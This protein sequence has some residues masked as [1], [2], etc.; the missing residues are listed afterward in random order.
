MIKLGIIA[1]SGLLPITVAKS[2]RKAGGDVVIAGLENY[3]T[4]EDFV[5]YECQIFNL[6][7]VGAILKFFKSHDISNLVIVGHIKRPDF[8]ALSLDLK[9]TLLLAKIMAA[10][11][12]GDDALLKL[13]ANFIES[14][15]F[16]INSPMKYMNSPSIETKI[17]PRKIDIENIEYAKKIA[18]ELGKFDIGQSVIVENGYILGVEAAEGTDALIERCG[19]I[20]KSNKSSILVKISK[21]RQ[22]ERLDIPTIGVE[23]I[24]NASK[25]NMAGMAIEKGRV[26]V[27]EPDKVKETAD[28]LGLFVSLI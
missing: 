10:K 15:G 22:D 6:G 11:L 27:L 9:G 26:I 20:R 18:L 25:A 5:S 12:L 1:G 8:A 13:V 19:I 28:N 14:E 23:T 17:Q 7:K 21:P 3:A 16:T 4:Q 2:Y 24:I